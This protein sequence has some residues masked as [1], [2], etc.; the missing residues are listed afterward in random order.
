MFNVS[1]QML[2]LRDHFRVAG[3]LG[4]LEGARERGACAP[5]FSQRVPHHGRANQRSRLRNGRNGWQLQNLFIPLKAFGGVPPDHPKVHQPPCDVGRFGW[6]ALLD[7]PRQGATVAVEIV[8]HAI[9]PFGLRRT[10]QPLRS[11]GGFAGAVARQSC[12]CIVAL[13]G[14]DELESRVSAHGFE[15]LEQR[16]SRHWG[17]GS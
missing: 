8:T 2:S 16:T 5:E 11:E 4:E 10:E 3:A 1:E 14:L 12:Q 6:P 13:A 7:E 15:H 9:Q 17:F